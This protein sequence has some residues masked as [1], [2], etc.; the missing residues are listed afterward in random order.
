MGKLKFS[1]R[2][3]L[4]YRWKSLQTEWQ[5]TVSKLCDLA[6]VAT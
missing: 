6:L 3:V 4:R 1:V 5:F 2:N